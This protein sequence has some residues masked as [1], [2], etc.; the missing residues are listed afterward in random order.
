MKDGVPEFVSQFP[1]WGEILQSQMGEVNR[2]AGCQSWR[3]ALLSSSDPAV[4]RASVMILNLDRANWFV[5]TGLPSESRVLDLG[6][7]MGTNSHAL[8]LRYREVIAVEPVAERV[9]FMRER[10]RQEGISNVHILQTSLWDLPFERESF[11]LV[12]MNGVLEWVAEGRT[13]DPKRLQAAAL[14]IAAKLLRPGAMLYLGFEN[15]LAAGYFVGYRNPI[16]AFLGS[17]SCRA[18]WR[19][20]T[21]V[22]RDNR[23]ATATTSTPAADTGNCC[24]NAGSPAAHVM[25]RSQLQ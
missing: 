18:G 25:W 9:Q 24:A 8:A 1:Y 17:Q 5:L 20:G 15:R 13:G 3:T 7:G 16:A 2:Q 21:L 12:V 6:A 22:P 19:T 23:A 11:D 4:K 10:F 14:E